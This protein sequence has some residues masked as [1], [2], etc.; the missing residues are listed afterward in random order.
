MDSTIF[1]KQPPSLDRSEDASARPV[2]RPPRVLVVDDDEANRWLVGRTLRTSGY[3]LVVAADGEEGLRMAVASPPDLILCDLDMPRM[4]GAELLRAVRAEASLQFVPFIVLTGRGD[5]H[6]RF[7]LLRDGAQDYLVKPFTAEELRVRVAN[8]LQVKIARD[9]LQ[10][11]LASR[12]SDVRVLI[13]EVAQ[14]RAAL[15]LAQ[16]EAQ[17]AS[18]AK[19]DFLTLVSHEFRTPLTVLRLNTEVWRRRTPEAR[20]ATDPELLRFEG[21]ISR[22]ESLVDSLLEAARVQSG[23]LE[24]HLEEIN[25]R[26][27]IA[28][29]VRELDTQIQARGLSLRIDVSDEAS[30]V[31]SDPRLLWLIISN[32]LGNA[33]KYTDAGEIELRV[34]RANGTVLE[35]R[36]LGPGIN[37]EDAER[38]FEP[39]VQLEQI[40]HKTKVGVGL[41]LSLVRDL[42]AALG[43]RV[44][45]QSQL[46]R[47]STFSVIL[48]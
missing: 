39:F 5:D 19:S 13:A 37:S 6:L 41:G 17:Q 25:L 29:L 45:L 35:V 21:A 44:G 42:T 11:E 1:V 48:P 38:I 10:E 20:P 9:L 23:R 47:G 14:R 32:L 40:E 27:L 31:R 46:G 2:H 18:R 24:L 16:D 34:F 33:I 22:L 28:Q 12:S 30:W 8:H 4:T 36:D 7:E 26:D 15:Q 3:D 43:G